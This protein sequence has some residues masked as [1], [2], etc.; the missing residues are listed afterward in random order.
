MFC[1]NCGKEI[2][3]GASFCTGCGK[4]IKSMEAS[5]QSAE[6]NP[7]IEK[8]VDT[9]PVKAEP[10]TEEIKKEDENIKEI[11]T[12]TEKRQTDDI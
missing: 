12:E 2:K 9:Q 10:H 3:D 7:C 5:S 4:K 6:L 11:V 1:T 8:N